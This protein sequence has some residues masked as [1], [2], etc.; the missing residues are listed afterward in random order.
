MRT[1]TT[2]KIAALLISQL[3]AGAASANLIR[4]G[5]FE[6][7]PV[8]ELYLPAGSTYMPGW[9]VINETITQVHTNFYGGVSSSEGSQ[10]LDL[11]GYYGRGGIKSDNFSTTIGNTYTVQFALGAFSVTGTNVVLDVWVNNIKFTTFVNMLDPGKYSDWETKTFSFMATDALTSLSFSVSQDPS[12]NRAGVG[13]DNVI[14]TA[15]GT[16]T[17]VPEPGIAGLALSG[18]LGM[19]WMRRRKK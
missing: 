11:S 8:S 14:V 19:A 15:G 12:T 1:S 10:L 6:E 4:N 2:F 17:Q 3:I 9:T 5:G 13:L 18:L 16:P 7:R